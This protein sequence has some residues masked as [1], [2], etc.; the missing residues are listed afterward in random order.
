MAPRVAKHCDF[1]Q[2][3]RTLSVAERKKYLNQAKASEIRA[4]S[5]CAYNVC[6]GNLNLSRAR[7]AKL[8]PYRVALRKLN[9][10]GSTVKHKRDILIQQGGFLPQLLA[11]AVP[12]I[13]SLFT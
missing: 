1:L 4:I 3:L 8:R 10:P 13:I 6:C 7:L 9:S 12:A 11:A 5:D 2:K